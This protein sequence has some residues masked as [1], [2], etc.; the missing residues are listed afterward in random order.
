MCSHY[1]IIQYV[2]H[3]LSRYYNDIS[4]VIFVV[5]YFAMQCA[6]IPFVLKYMPIL[7]GR[8]KLKVEHKLV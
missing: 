3:Y 7:A 5:V 6:C 4:C 8:K 1:E 2:T